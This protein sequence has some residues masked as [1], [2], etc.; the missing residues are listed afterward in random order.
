MKKALPF[1]IMIVIV[2]SQFLSTT[3]LVFA[4]NDEFLGWNDWRPRRFGNEQLFSFGVDCPIINT[5]DEEIVFYVSKMV[6]ELMVDY[7]NSSYD[8]KTMIL[9]FRYRPESG[10]RDEASKHYNRI[11]NILNLKYGNPSGGSI[12]EITPLLSGSPNVKSYTID[13]KINIVSR[14]RGDNLGERLISIANEAKKFSNITKNQLEYINNYLAKNVKYDDAGDS[15]H[16]ALFDGIA[17]C[18][19]Y[20]NMVQ[21]LCYLLGVPVVFISSDTVNH[22]WNSVYIDGEWKMWDATWDKGSN[23]YFLVDKIDS[24]SH[25]YDKE[26]FDFIK[27]LYLK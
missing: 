27:R 20:A 26:L 23:K 22:A 19:G 2:S 7:G 1:L 8:I 13:V 18:Q 14:V 16:Q 5:S 24:P 6:D 3:D 17:R 9:Y 10:D 12:I 25:I 4:Q 11:Y 21:I 15:I